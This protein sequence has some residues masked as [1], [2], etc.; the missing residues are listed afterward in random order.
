MSNVDVTIVRVSP[1]GA[2]LVE[3]EGKQAW[4][5]P[6]ALKAL[7]AGRVQPAVAK[8]LASAPTRAEFVASRR[9]EDAA[10]R[11]RNEQMITLP[12]TPAWENESSVGFDFV[13]ACEITDQT[14]RARAFILRRDIIAGAAPRWKIEKAIDRAMERVTAGYQGASSVEPEGSLIDAVRE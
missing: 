12:G 10:R 14:R 2:G 5:R 1:R 9:A 11:E 13:A 6:A 4:I 8:A 7:Q 3:F